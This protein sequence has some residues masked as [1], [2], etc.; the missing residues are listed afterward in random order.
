VEETAMNLRPALVPIIL[1]AVALSAAAQVPLNSPEGLAFDAQGNLYVANYGT[2][3]VL[4]YD[5]QLTQTGSISEGLS[6]PTRLA[7]DGA[8]DLYVANSTSNSITVYDPSG[9]QITSKTITKDV[10]RPLAVAVNSSGDVF[11][12]N[13]AVS[14]ISVYNSAGT[15]L[16]TYHHDNHHNHF[17]VG[18]M[19]I[20]GPNVYI[21]TGPTAG[22][23][24]INSYNIDLLLQGHAR[25]VVTYF[26]TADEGPTGI[27]FDA[28]GNVY[29]YTGTAVKYSPSNQV[30]LT[31]NTGHYGQ[32]EG[33]AVDSQGNIYISFGS[34]TINVY[35]SSGTLINTLH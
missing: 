4:I 2:N 11:V 19:A 27:A 29:Y 35:N 34:N 33:I 6:G 32:G 21:G 5:S 14:D 31:L 10:N 7:F 24:F 9:N 3:Q 8:G 15:L 28:S 12:G 1:A 18:A 23:S 25:E 22:Q 13:N 30:L 20:L 17:L 26:D 16:G